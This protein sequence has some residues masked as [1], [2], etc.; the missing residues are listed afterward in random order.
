M[1][2]SGEELIGST[3]FTVRDFWSWLASDLRSNTTRSSLAEFNVAIAVGAQ[4]YTNI[5]GFI[6]C[7]LASRNQDRG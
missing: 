5:V 7:P 2:L 3:S 4:L 6:R 1:R